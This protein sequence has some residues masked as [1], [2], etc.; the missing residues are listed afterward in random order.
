MR[1]GQCVA[2]TGVRAPTPCV[3]WAVSESGWC[4][5]HYASKLER[6]RR[7]EKEAARMALL[8]SRADA[9]IAWTAAHP[10]IFDN[11]GDAKYRKR[12]PPFRLEAP[13]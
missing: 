12:K 11:P 6:I 8:N 10:S 2:V 7:E 1:F 4:W 9:H 5:Q 3:R 13:A